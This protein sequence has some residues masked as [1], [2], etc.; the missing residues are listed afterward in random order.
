MHCSQIKMLVAK[1]VNDN[2]VATGTIT[3]THFSKALLMFHCMVQG[4]T[5]WKFFMYENFK[6]NFF[7]IPRKFFLH[8]TALEEPTVLATFV[9][10]RKQLL[11]LVCPWSIE[12][13][14]CKQNSGPTER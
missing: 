9:T 7:C 3:W 2:R 1:S 14:G 11:V 13:S 10:F 5:N 8:A 4:N 6:E 12:E